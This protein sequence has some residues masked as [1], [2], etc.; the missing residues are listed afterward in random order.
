M[1]SLHSFLANCGNPYYSPAI[2]VLFKHR[3]DRW[4]AKF[5]PDWDRFGIPKKKKAVT[6]IA[7]ARLSFD[8]SA[9]FSSLSNIMK[10]AEY[11]YHIWPIYY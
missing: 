10:G 2:P 8:Y 7:V 3:N 4:Q 1:K 6:G 9:P 11:I 5:L